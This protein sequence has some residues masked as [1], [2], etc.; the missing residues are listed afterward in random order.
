MEFKKKAK[1]NSKIFIINGNYSD[2][3]AALLDRG[4]LENPDS[5]SMLFDL[6]W[7]AKTKDIDFNSL[8]EEQLVNHFANNGCLTTKYGL[9][10]SLRSMIYNQ[11]VDVF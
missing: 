7:T 9:C 4:W 10:R 1:A 2:L 5:R 6:K 11:S 8:E 3:R